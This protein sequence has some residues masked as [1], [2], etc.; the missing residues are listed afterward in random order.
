MLI[1]WRHIYIPGCFFCSRNG[2]KH[3]RR[4]E[5]FMQHRHIANCPY[6][7]LSVSSTLQ[8]PETEHW[9][10][11]KPIPSSQITLSCDW[12]ICSAVLSA[13]QK[14]QECNIWRLQNHEMSFISPQMPFKLHHLDCWYMRTFFV[15]ICLAHAGWRWWIFLCWMK[16]GEHGRPFSRVGIADCLRLSPLIQGHVSQSVRRCEALGY[17]KTE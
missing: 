2:N 17:K 15:S 13:L 10:R 4:G 5:P 14:S 6:C 7:F 11:K 12:T 16:T 1:S 3:K 9:D 8:N